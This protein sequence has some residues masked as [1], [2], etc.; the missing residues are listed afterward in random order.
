M[1]LVTLW[2]TVDSYQWAKSYVSLHTERSGMDLGLTVGAV[3][4]AITAL[5]TIVFGQ[6]VGSRPPKDKD[7]SAS[8]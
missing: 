2:L 6:Y 8:G 3:L 5:Q 1:L 7:E 4:A